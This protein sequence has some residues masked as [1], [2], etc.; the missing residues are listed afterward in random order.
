MRESLILRVDIANTA[1]NPLES[2]LYLP[3]KGFLEK[4][5]Y[6]PGRQYLW[7]DRYA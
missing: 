7:M 2:S 4:L 3:V 1:E 6:L 5:G